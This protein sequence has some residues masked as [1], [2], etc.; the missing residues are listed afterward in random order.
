MRQDTL[1]KNRNEKISNDDGVRFPAT[2][3]QFTSPSNYLS[4][5]NVRELTAFCLLSATS[6]TATLKQALKFPVV[7]PER[8]QRALSCQNQPNADFGT[9]G[10]DRVPCARDG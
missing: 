9:L 4:A 7:N 1:R 6:H 5:T 2:Q 10:A 3:P 8:K